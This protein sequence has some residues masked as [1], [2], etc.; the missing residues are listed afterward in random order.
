MRHCLPAAQRPSTSYGLSSCS[1]DN[2][3]NLMIINCIV[4]EDIG[5]DIVAWMFISTHNG[6]SQVVRLS[7]RLQMGVIKAERVIG[8]PCRR[9]RCAHP[10][11][12]HVPRRS[13]NWSDSASSPVFLVYPP[14]TSMKYQQRP[15]TLP[16]ILL[17]AHLFVYTTNVLSVELSLTG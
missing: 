6:M 7:H 12:S 9:P 15:R 1:Y 14:W 11:N 4:P 10:S 8:I 2:N 17:L 3:R 13:F 5:V 16:I